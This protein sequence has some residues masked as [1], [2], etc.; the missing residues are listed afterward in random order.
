MLALK[1]IIFPGELQTYANFNRFLYRKVYNPI[2]TS[3][4]NTSNGPETKKS[5]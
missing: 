2:L 1:G 3:Y 5:F 4:E